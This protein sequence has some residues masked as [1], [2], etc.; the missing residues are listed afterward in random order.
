MNPPSTGPGPTQATQAATAS[1]AAERLQ[2]AL[3]AGAIVGTW[4]WDVP[5]D[6]F[7]ADER[8]AR[9]FGLSAQRCVD[10][11][12]LDEVM[13]S[14]HPE[15]S[16]R[17]AAAIAEALGRGGPYRCEY[18]V[19]QTDGVYRWI[20]ANGRVELDSTG[21]PVRFPGVLLDI[22][23]RRAAEAERDRLTALLSTFTAAVPGVVYAKDVAGRMLVA[24]HGTTELIGKPP[25]FYLGKTDVEFL[26]DKAQARQI[27]ATDQR[28]MRGGKAEQIEE[29]VDMP[30]GSAVVWLSV[31]APLF[32]DAGE[33]IGLIG[34]SID[35]TARKTAEAALQDLNHT[36][37]ARVA[38]AISE[39]EAAEAALRQAQKMEAVGQ[40]TGG[41]AHDFNNLLAGIS[42]SLEMMQMRL[43]QGRGA[44]IDRY[45]SVAQGAV[46]RAA[47]LTH[48]LLA[49]SRQQTL[50]PVPTDVNGLI[51]GMEELIRRSVG[52]AVGIS[53]DLAA[54]LWPALVDPAQ[55][56]NALL[57]LCINARDAM[58]GGGS[59]VIQTYNTHLAAGADLAPELAPGEYLT[60]C[61]SDTGV[62]MGAH[63]LARAC[64]PFF[65][66]K[67]AGA[68]TGL[69]LSM[70][71]GFARQSGGQIRIHS[72]PGVGT[73]V[74]LHLP[75][76][77]AP[78]V[79]RNALPSFAGAHR[80]VSGVTV[81]VVDD[82]ASMRVLLTEL[83]TGQGYV[84]IEAADGHA[85]LQL[86]RSDVRIDLLVTDVGLPGG[87]NG[88]QMA[89]AG[90][91]A[92]PGLPVLFMTGYAQSHVLDQ[93]H[94]E[95][96]TELLTKPFAL[97]AL[98]TQVS[99]LLGDQRTPR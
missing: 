40:L 46:Q 35:V 38:A 51:R 42:G 25:A 56:E 60:I 97:D 24:N 30:D 76:H 58:P 28:I 49:F 87:M 86:L 79:S 18:R 14:I 36:L 2:L 5:N 48:R 55:V 10:G 85:G 6:H 66:T 39:R 89:D 75:H 45:L 50:A 16:A 21:Q 88:R 83:L 8:F 90:R 3:D 70:V 98:M 4:V 82:E 61:V 26:E 52:P 64:E 19:L 43:A 27:M 92:R 73:Q 65:T 91:L 23:M 96:A 33:V 12:S 77:A 17:V 67:P 63:V 69:G 44:E 47:A 57:N 11:L 81:L 37:E 59:I 53:V 15:D 32:N 94:L 54:E 71:Y 41:I 80:T 20:E 1:D 9:S 29:R 95:P 31:K 84:V 7:S 13:A 22:E 62:G 93:C 99:G 74:Y 78:V 72:E 68:G 34:S